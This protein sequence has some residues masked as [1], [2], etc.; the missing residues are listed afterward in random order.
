MDLG[1]FKGFK[2]FFSGD[3]LLVVGGYF[4]GLR[5]TSFSYLSKKRL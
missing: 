2:I 4:A 3:F 5:G 1:F